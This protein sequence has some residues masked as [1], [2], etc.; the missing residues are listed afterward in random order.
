M[1]EVFP[2][3]L[4][5][6]FE[7]VSGDDRERGVERKQ[8]CATQTVRTVSRKKPELMTRSQVTHLDLRANRSSGTHKN[9]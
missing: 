4:G 9:K 1:A 7:R 2:D 6:V 5:D 8:V 3:A